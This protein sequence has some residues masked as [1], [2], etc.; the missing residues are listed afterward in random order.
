MKDIVNNKVNNS[1]FL[2]NLYGDN[3]IASMT[4]PKGVIIFVSHA[5]EIISGYTKDE[6]IGKPHNIIRHP[7]MPSETFRELWATIQLGNTWEGEILNLNKAGHPYWVKTKI[8]PKFDSNGNITGYASVREDIT[9]KKNLDKLHRQVTNVL[10]NIDEGFLIFNNDLKINE[11]YSKKC[12]E[13]LNQETIGQKNISDVLFS[14]SLEVKEI[15]DYAYR[16]ILNTQDDFSKELLLSLLPTEHYNDNYIFT[17]EYKLLINNECLILISDVT[18]QRKLE[19]IIKH[20]QQM[21]KMIIAIATHKKETIDLNVSFQKFLE[22]IED[23]PHSEENENTILEKLKRDLHT[24]KGL[25]A[26]LEM[27]YTTDAIHDIEAMIVSND[28]GVELLLIFLKSN[29]EMAFNRDLKVITDILGDDFLSTSTFVNVELNHIKSV[30]KK[31]KMI[32]DN[33]H[34]DKAIFYDLLNDITSMQDQPFIDMLSI[35]STTV[36]NISENIKKEMY[37]LKIIGDRKI[38]VS[39]SF[40]GFIDSLVHIFRNSMVHGIEDSETRRTLHKDICGNISCCYELIDENIVLTIADDGQGIDTK[41]IIE[42]AIYLKIIEKNEVAT[43][44]EQEILK[45]VFHTGFSTTE[46]L[47]SLAGRGVGLASVYHELLNLQGSVQIYNK[48]KI[49][50]SFVFT[51]PHQQIR[52][53]DIQKMYESELLINDI[54]TESKSFLQDDMNIE[55][56]SIEVD[57]DFK[58]DSYYSTIKLSGHKEIFCILCVDEP[59]IDKIFGV[60]IP[61]EITD[62]E[63]NDI[64]KTLPDEIINTVVGLSI[65]RFPKEYKELDMSIPILLDQAVIELLNNDNLSITKKINTSYGSLKCTIIMIEEDK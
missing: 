10:D 62:E 61:Y 50:L 21:Q 9:V 28:L 55:V 19:K 30:E 49:G 59:L 43:L 48:P 40:K 13:I 56:S 29:L 34:E 46:E 11:N 58:L 25:F 1:E 47:T 39:D 4:D 52:V 26:Q 24:F 20:E 7:D 57:T 54:I 35:Y 8:T 65:S 45:L 15:F 38:L 37:P 3:V 27:L 17:L 6:L 2:L 5:Y 60:F 44:S 36:K 41:K 33:L 22:N 16:E 42:K 31:V 51:I 18:H 64:I 63:K 14:N 53:N 32:I 23:Y 12:L